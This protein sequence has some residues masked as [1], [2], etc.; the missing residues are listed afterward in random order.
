MTGN[1]AIYSCRLPP[2]PSFF[3]GHPSA[4]NVHVTLSADGVPSRYSL[5]INGTHLTVN[6]MS[7]SEIQV[8]LNGFMRYV[9]HLHHTTP[10]GHTQPLLARLK[11]MCTVLGVIIE[12][13][14][15]EEE[16]AAEF[17]W[18]VAEA[19]DALVFAADSVFS[20]SGEPLVGPA[21]RAEV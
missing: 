12:P 9:T 14:Y 16:Q 5:D 7:H 10:S 13:D 11:D 3:E 18:S 6:V 20:C 19:L 8:H 17:V 15:D 2:D 4:T 1:A 21:T